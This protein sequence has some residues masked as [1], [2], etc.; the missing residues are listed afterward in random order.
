[1][2]HN[3]KT[4]HVSCKKPCLS[5]GM[6]GPQDGE[7]LP[8]ASEARHTCWRKGYCTT[9]FSGESFFHSRLEHILQDHYPDQQVKLEY[10]C[11][12]WTHP[13][14]KDHW[15]TEAHITRLNE[16]TGSQMVESIHSSPADRFDMHNISGAAHQALLVYHGKH[17]EEMKDDKQKYLPRHPPGSLQV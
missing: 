17:Y 11:T 5:T 16:F 7:A 15:S 4:T 14:Y 2:V 3:E 6:M 10:K 13:K 1:M 12:E 8:A 9:S